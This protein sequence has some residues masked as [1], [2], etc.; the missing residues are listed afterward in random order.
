MEARNEY[1]LPVNQEYFKNIDREKSPAHK[2]KLKYAVDFACPEGTPI[3]ASRSGEIVF[4]REDSDVGGPNEKY[5]NMGNRLVIRHENGEYTAYE[6]FKYNSSTVKVGD[7]VKTGQIICRS[8]NTGYT[9][10]PHLHFEVFKFIGPNKDE[11]YQTLKVEFPEERS[12]PHSKLERILVGSFF[13]ISS[14]AFFSIHYI[15][16]KDTSGFKPSEELPPSKFNLL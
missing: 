13:L 10:G 3:K 16:G 5:W 14:I 9:F 8:G 4:V 6:H 12:P 15:R 7:K 2:G 1:Q 11:D